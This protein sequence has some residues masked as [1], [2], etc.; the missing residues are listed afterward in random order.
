MKLCNLYKID[1]RINFEFDS[2]SRLRKINDVY[3]FWSIV[4]FFFFDLYSCLFL[5]PQTPINK[6]KVGRCLLRINK[7]IDLVIRNIFCLIFVF[8]RAI[9]KLMAKC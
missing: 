3:L 8:I 9:I 4:S 2:K 7:P 1:K 5:Q 6:L